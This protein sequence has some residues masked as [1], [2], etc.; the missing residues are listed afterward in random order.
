MNT[1]EIS[2]ITSFNQQYA[3]RINRFEQINKKFYIAS[4]L[5]LLFF[6]SNVLF[7]MVDE[8]IPSE[9]ALYE[10]SNKNRGK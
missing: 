8:F 9:K 7:I 6:L 4:I 3:S 1:N 10:I 2:L 5:L